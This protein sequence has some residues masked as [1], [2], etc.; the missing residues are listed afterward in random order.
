MVKCKQRIADVLLE[1]KLAGKGAVLIDKGAETL[2]RL[3]D[4]IN[5]DKMPKPSFKMVLTAVGEY[6][7]RRPQ[8]DVWVV[9]IGVL[10]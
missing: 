5:T 2:C 7:Y 4:K 3:S 8:D 9:P 6:S 10:R 1:R